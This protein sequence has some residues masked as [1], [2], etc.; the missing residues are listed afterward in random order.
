MKEITPF[1]YNLPKK[2]DAEETLPNLC[3]KPTLFNKRLAKDIA[4]KKKKT[5]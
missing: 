5:N 1:L 4:G 2:I 3:M